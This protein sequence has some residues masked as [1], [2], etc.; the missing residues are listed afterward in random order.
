MKELIISKTPDSAEIFFV[1]EINNPEIKWEEAG[2]EF[3]LNGKLYDI[4]KT[5]NITGRVFLF[6]LNDEKESKL[7][8][9]YAKAI[10]SQT[11]NSNGKNKFNIKPYVIDYFFNQ[12]EKII[13]FTHCIQKRYMPF[14]SGI[15]SFFLVVDSPPPRSD[16]YYIV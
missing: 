14:D 15:Y 10:K 1:T 16:F 12:H 7:F 9:D 5:K 3:Y 4:V 11:D 8:L 6:C 2:S 13:S